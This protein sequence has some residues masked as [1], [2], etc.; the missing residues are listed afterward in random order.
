MGVLGLVVA[1]V[2]IGLTYILL[3]KGLAETTR[4]GSGRCTW[5]TAWSA[6]PGRSSSCPRRRERPVL[7]ADRLPRAVHRDRHGLPVPAARP[8]PQAGCA[9]QDSQR[10]RDL[11]GKHGDRDSLGYFTLRS[12]K[13]VIWS[14][15]GKSCIGYRVVSGVMLAGGD[16]LGDP[17]AWPGAI[18]AF[19]D[20][21]ARHAWV[22]A[23]MGCGEQAPRCGAGKAG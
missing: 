22:P 18:H 4:C 12:D 5:S 16:P 10:V 8:S 1:D 17:E 20:E 14:P 13:S 15:T 2:A 3:A 9:P 19:L 6:S 7:P 11:L 23:V 21:A